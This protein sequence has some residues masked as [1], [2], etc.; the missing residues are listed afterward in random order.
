[1]FYPWD[2]IDHVD[3]LKDW[4]MFRE[5]FGFEESSALICQTKRYP[6]KCLVYVESLYPDGVK[7]M[8]KQDE[9]EF[10]NGEYQYDYITEE[11]ALYELN[12]NSMCYFDVWDYEAVCKKFPNLSCPLNPFCY[13]HQFIGGYDGHYR[14]KIVP[15]IP[16]PSSA[17][18]PDG[19]M[20]YYSFSH[21][22]D[23]MEDGTHIYYP[24]KPKLRS[25][26]QILLSNGEFVKWIHGERGLTWFLKEKFRLI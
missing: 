12:W 17:N 22:L 20:W 3:K 18:P 6:D 4:T 26:I 11:D 1:M 16:K 9:Y 24:L 5:N 19:Y 14:A 21:S 15:K 7:A 25:V 2:F 23:T 8:I 10:I 13:V